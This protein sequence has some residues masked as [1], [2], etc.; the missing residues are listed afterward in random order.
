MHF[1]PPG[2]DF[3]YNRLRNSL[4]VVH[5]LIKMPNVKAKMPI[6]GKLSDLF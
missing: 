6:E 5:Q 4:L 1:I 2:V 3:P